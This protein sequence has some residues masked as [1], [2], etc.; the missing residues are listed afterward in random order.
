[1]IF[2]DDLP[3]LWYPTSDVR[4]NAVRRSRVRFRA[5]LGIENQ[6]PVHEYSQMRIVMISKHAS[7]VVRLI[8][9]QSYNLTHSTSHS[10]S[11]NR[12]YCIH[13]YVSCCMDHQF[14]L[15]LRETN[16]QHWLELS[17]Y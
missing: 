5:A 8:H 4:T 6:T 3:R 1:M 9:R 2:V 12:I 11:R 10:A 14:I 17:A 16:F 7:G 15:D 13:T